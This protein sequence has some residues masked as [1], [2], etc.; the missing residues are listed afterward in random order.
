[1]PQLIPAGSLVTVPVPVPLLETV[2][3]CGYTSAGTE[4]FVVELFPSWP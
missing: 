1:M 3:A 4:L 2:S